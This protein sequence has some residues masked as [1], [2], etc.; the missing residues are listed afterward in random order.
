MNRRGFLKLIGTGALMAAMPGTITSKPKQNNNPIE[1][2]LSKKDEAPI[3][4]EKMELSPTSVVEHD[5]PKFE[6]DDTSNEEKVKTPEF[7]QNYDKPF[8]HIETNKIAENL[9]IKLPD[10]YNPSQERTR[11]FKELENTMEI[12]PIFIPEVEAWSDLVTELC[13]EH[14]EENPN[15]KISPNTILALMSIESQG[16]EK[17]YSQASAVGLMQLTEQV[18]GTREFGGYTEGQIFD[19]IKN[20]RVSLMYLSDIL[21]KA[22]NLG[23]GG[24]DLWQY[25]AMEYNGGSRNAS[26]YFKT[27][28]ALDVFGAEGEIFRVDDFEDV[29]KY[30]KENKGNTS[31]AIEFGTNMV[32]R[33][34]LMYREK[35]ARFQVIA[36]V[37]KK[38]LQD[39]YSKEDI[40]EML[41]ISDIVKRTSAEIFR[42]KENLKKDKGF[43]TYFD[44]KKISDDLS[45]PY[46]D[47]SVLSQVAKEDD[48]NSANILLSNSFYL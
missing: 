33:E 40:K 12:L 2:P 26:R 34:T 15:N 41:S 46:F 43:I 3:K 13:F 36:E 1:N 42:R 18:Y 6:L 35:F 14:N 37:A 11:N 23:L 47:Y 44:V 31:G 45:S 38:L 21:T 9:G 19:P 39:G 17:A 5:I 29:L 30:L 7:N 25:V 4:V 20:I 27:P 32:M 10:L 16:Y 24:S 28:P 8:S 48:R 22:K